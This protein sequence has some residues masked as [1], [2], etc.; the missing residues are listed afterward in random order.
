[1]ADS[2]T[3]T[4]ATVNS[5]PS[6]D[7]RATSYRATASPFCAARP[8][9]RAALLTL[10]L[11]AGLPIACKAS[12]Q[13][14]PAGG[15]SAGSGGDTAE[16]GG[17]GGLDG[18]GGTGGE[19]SDPWRSARAWI[20]PS[21]PECDNA[22]AALGVDDALLSPFADVPL[23]SLGLDEATRATFYPH[24]QQLPGS[25]TTLSEVL[26][27]PLR[28][29]CEALR[30]TGAART[31][32]ADQRPLT[33]LVASAAY[34][35]QM[36][37]LV[38][39]ASAWSPT[40][41]S[42]QASLLQLLSDA[43]FAAKPMKGAPSL[44]EQLEGVPHS[45]AALTRHL[46]VNALEALALR[47]TALVQMEAAGSTRKLAFDRMR[48]LY[49]P[50]TG[51]FFSP[52]DPGELAFLA[53]AAK[54]LVP[55]YA[56]AAIL[57]QALD[58][59]LL[60]SSALAD[61]SV[62]SQDRSALFSFTASTNLGL[63]LLR[64]GAND[65]YGAKD[66]PEEDAAILLTIDTG[67]DDEILSNA[68]ATVAAEHGVSLH[69]DLGGADNY[70]YDAV[71]AAP[72]GLLAP[73]SDGRFAG[74]P[75]GYGTISLSMHPRQGSGILGYGMLVDLG[76]TADRYR[77][78]RF[79]QGFANVGVGVLWDDG[80]DDRYEAE[81]ASQA[82]SIA[83]LALLVDR[84]GDDSYTAF[85]DAQAMANPGGYALLQDQAGNDSYVLQAQPLLFPW[86]DG[87]DSNVSRGQ[88][89][90]HGLRRS[91]EL[92]DQNLFGG[93]ALL[94]DLG[95]DDSYEAAVMAQGNGYWG[96]FG[97]LADHA[98][99]DQYDVLVYGQAA[100]EHFGLGALLDG[101]VDGSS[102]DDRYNLRVTPRSL[103]QGSGHDFSVAALIDDGGSDQHR[104]RE[105]SLGASS[106]LGFGL[107][108]DRGGDDTYTALD[109]LCFGYAYEPPEAACNNFDGLPLVGLFAD[110]KGNDSYDLSAAAPA[111]ELQTFT[112]A[113]DSVWSAV[114]DPETGQ[115]E[116]GGGT[117]AAN[118]SSSID[119]LQTF[120]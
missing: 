62:P 88:G 58:E 110:L 51:T 35:R 3:S 76:G 36:S 116:L 61:S 27:A 73:D 78:L 91:N 24:L 56:G 23:T 97:V 40:T 95:G 79:G 103:T 96:G 41:E 118:A 109:A 66:S 26:A 83:G 7:P 102:S 114:D 86:F 6:S 8:S 77:T 67:G 1:M 117:D 113:Q 21:L 94:Q 65:V 30:L 48:R 104:A 100:G 22:Q 34:A 5:P 19:S 9:L 106:C 29:P 69:I 4:L 84:S 74:T 90:G 20:V 17:G 16:A 105:K 52:D 107:F 2:Q 81:A 42:A 59:S 112:P 87:F 68:G 47:E 55:L 92:E 33:H 46:L 82:A 28:L 115:Q 45:V 18:T 10:G 75:G 15:N 119:S 63:I 108:L 37:P 80:G 43:R 64:G 13:Q 101:S 60:A 50:S 72:E 39:G 54:A 99:N 44:A 14:P 71:A 120:P 12:M 31:A 111:P 53:P 25:I 70:H 11:F 89:A 49:A 85:Q 57:T 38:G 98:G 32:A 93:T